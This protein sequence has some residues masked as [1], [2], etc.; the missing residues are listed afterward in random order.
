MRIARLNFPFVAGQTS[1][2]QK[3]PLDAF[4]FALVIKI[5][6][7]D[8]T[9][10]PMATLSIYDPDGDLVFTKGSIAENMVTMIHAIAEAKDIPLIPDGDAVL[11][12]TG[13]PGIVSPNVTFYVV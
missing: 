13:A 2:T 8:C 7:P 1:N 12:F 4:G 3:L 6:I 5:D 10:T 11:T 9:G